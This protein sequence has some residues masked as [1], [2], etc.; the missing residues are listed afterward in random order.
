[1]LD[2][3]S[4]PRLLI[5]FVTLY[6]V[7]LLIY[8]RSLVFEML[9]AKC[10]VERFFPSFRMIKNDMQRGPLYLCMLLSNLLPTAS[11]DRIHM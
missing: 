6:P 8:A 10:T 4:L 3:I 7:I 5:R 1:M 2:L 9:D 11:L